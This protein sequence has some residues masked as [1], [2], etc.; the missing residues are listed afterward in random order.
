MRR[1]ASFTLQY[2]NSWHVHTHKDLVLVALCCPG[3]GRVCHDQLPTSSFHLLR[4]SGYT[5]Q[6]CDLRSTEIP[7]FTSDPRAAGHSIPAVAKSCL[8]NVGTFGSLKKKGFVA[9][10]CFSC[11]L[12]QQKL[13]S[14]CDNAEEIL[15]I[16]GQV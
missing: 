14:N 2:F 11:V 10:S 5:P 9:Q 1:C 16:Y 8:L 15:L 4:N 12:A 3:V 7:R 13:A 6:V